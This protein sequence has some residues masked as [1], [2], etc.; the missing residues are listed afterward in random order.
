MPAWKRRDEGLVLS[1]SAVE[2]ALVR[3]AATAAGRPAL[4]VLREALF[5]RPFPVP[6]VVADEGLRKA[7]KRVSEAVWPG[8]ERAVDL[9]RLAQLL[10]PVEQQ[11]DSR[12]RV[13]RTQLRREASQRGALAVRVP[14]DEAPAVVPEAVAQGARQRPP[15]RL[16]VDRRGSPRQPGRGPWGRTARVRLTIDER[17]ALDDAAR[18][19]GVTPSLLVRHV[20]FGV[21]LQASWV[22][23]EDDELGRLFAGWGATL[24]QL[25]QQYPERS[26]EAGL[27]LDGSVRAS[28]CA[29]RLHRLYRTQYAETEQRE[30]RDWA[31]SRAMWRKLLGRPVRP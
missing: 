7:A 14:E 23:S 21:D 18:A 6:P 26:E 9:T 24:R 16:Q 4:T 1:L 31:R 15:R 27:A 30:R 12:L 10:G 19:R 3:H 29:Q 13:V 17:E 8:P 2:F 20:L 22:P 25:A 5:A 11:L 28:G